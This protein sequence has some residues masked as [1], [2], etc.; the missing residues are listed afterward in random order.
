MSLYAH[1]SHTVTVYPQEADT[2]ARGNAVFRASTTGVV[3]TGCL[4]HPVASTRGAFTA[5]DPRQ[6]QRVDASWKLVCRIDVPVEWWA[7]VEW[8]RSGGCPVDR[9]RF[10]VLGGPLRRNVSAATA[11]ITCTLQEIR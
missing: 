2:D 7:T 10:S 9:M 6:G 4:V 3:I 8:L 11:H 5:I 1:G